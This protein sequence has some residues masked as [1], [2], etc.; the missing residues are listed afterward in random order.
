MPLASENDGRVYFILFIT[1]SNK[2]EIVSFF[3][4]GENG[5]PDW[6]MRI[7]KRASIP[8]SPGHCFKCDH[9]LVLAR[10]FKQ[11]PAKRMIIQMIVTVMQRLMGIKITKTIALCFCIQ[12]EHY[13]SELSVKLVKK[14]I[15]LH[16][17]MYI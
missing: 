14:K 7:R 16:I 17:L 5:L 8:L 13:R 2:L 4:L 12:T 15:T 3:I 9:I 6:R 10:F 11:M 1:L